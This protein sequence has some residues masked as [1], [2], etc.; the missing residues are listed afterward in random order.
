MFLFLIV[1][2]SG[3]NRLEYLTLGLGVAI[4]VALVVVIILMCCIWIK[5]PRHCLVDFRTYRQEV[6]CLQ[7]YKDQNPGQPFDRMYYFEQRKRDLKAHRKDTKALELLLFPDR[8]H[9]SSCVQH[10]CSH[11]LGVVLECWRSR[12]SA[13]GRV[14]DCGPS[15]C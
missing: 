15:Q 4:L 11:V 14:N 3:I 13:G 6:K 5:C 12:W 8:Q 9:G 7:Q 10:C 1:A 2:V